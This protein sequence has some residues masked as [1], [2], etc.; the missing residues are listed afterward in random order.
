MPPIIHLQSVLI[1]R[2][3]MI[4]LAPFLLIL[5]LCMRIGRGIMSGLSEFSELFTAVWRGSEE[6][7]PLLPC[8]FCGGKGIPHGWRTQGG[9]TGPACDNCGATTWSADTWNTRITLTQEQLKSVQRHDD[10]AE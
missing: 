5:I 4:L 1:R 8:P 2:L 10:D 7:P 9:A 3:L 6:D